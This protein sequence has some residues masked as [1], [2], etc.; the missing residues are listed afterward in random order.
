MALGVNRTPTKPMPR[1]VVLSEGFTGRAHELK[2]EKTTIG[3]VE[4]NTFQIP[5]P[6]VSSHHCEILV[7]GNEVLVRDLGST[8]GTFINGQPVTEATLK[9]SQILRVG[10]VE[11]RLEGDAATTAAP[12]RVLD[13]T[14]I[15]PQGV[16]LDELD[17]GAR[18]ANNPAFEKKSDRGVKMFVVGSIIVA[19]GVIVVLV[20]VLSGVGK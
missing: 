12:K 8:N 4:D 5:D 3:R 20:Y 13:H 2:T 17:Q 11:V 14:Q 6:S 9:P 19:V 10:Q 1:L 7:R 16:K 18:A 15:V